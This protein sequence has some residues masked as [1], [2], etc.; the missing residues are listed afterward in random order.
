MKQIAVAVVALLF[1]SVTYAGTP[2]NSVSGPKGMEK[3]KSLVGTWEGKDKDGAPLEVTYKLVSAGTSLMETINHG[4]QKDNMVTIYHLDGDNLMMTHYCSMGN[5]PRM[6]ESAS[7]KSSLT[8][9][10]VDGTNMKSGDPH[11]HKL[12]LSWSGDNSLTQ[13]WTMRSEGK[14]TPP[15]V[16]K[17]ARTKG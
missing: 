1:V 17:L 8:F 3:L 4:A 10:F 9:S 6:K 7:D 11:M 2:G 15:V 16:F 12:V 14:D 13:E 5:Q